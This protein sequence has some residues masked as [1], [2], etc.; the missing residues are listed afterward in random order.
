MLQAAG[1][2]ARYMSLLSPTVTGGAVLEGKGLAC[3]RRLA[4]AGDAL[5][6]GAGERRLLPLEATKEPSASGNRP[7]AL[8]HT[9]SFTSMGDTGTIPDQ[10]AP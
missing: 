6:Y 2:P 4:I 8:D 5:S 9:R 7:S 1:G 10:R 3:V